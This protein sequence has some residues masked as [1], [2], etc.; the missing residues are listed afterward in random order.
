MKQRIA[1][2]LRD[3]HFRSYLKMVLCLGTVLEELVGWAERCPCHEAIQAGFLRRH[4]PAAVLRLEFG[5]RYTSRCQMTC[6]MRGR[7]AAEFAAGGVL[8]HLDLAWRNSVSE[9]ALSC[10]QYLTHE[11][12]SGILM[13]LDRAKSHC[14]Y[15]LSMKLIHWQQLPWLLCGLSHVNEETA[16]GIANTCIAQFDQAPL[17]V[18]VHHRVSFKFLAPGTLRTQLQA[19]ADGTPRRELPELYIEIAKLRCVPVTEREIEGPH[20]RIKKR[21]A[22]RRRFYFSF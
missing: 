9:L 15:I 20:G 16:R 18:A 22:H 6:P 12:W 8:E 17:A 4:I 21:I 1:R 3:S 10:R 13:E 19:F 14:V 2:L 5:E 7:R 11:Q